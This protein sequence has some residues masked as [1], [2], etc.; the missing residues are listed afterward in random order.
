MLANVVGEGASWQLI[1]IICTISVSIVLALAGAL[2]H[3]VAARFNRQSV[4]HEDL[5][6]AFYDFMGATRERMARIEGHVAEVDK[7]YW[8]NIP[9]LWDK[10]DAADHRCA[11]Q[12]GQKGGE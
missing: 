11:A 12:H 8:D 10:V 6:K 2:T 9:K 5:R 1:A 3:Q 7:K 4:K